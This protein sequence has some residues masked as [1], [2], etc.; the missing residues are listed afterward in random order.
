[1]NTF[2]LTLRDSDIPMG[3]PATRVY[4]SGGSITIEGEQIL[5]TVSPTNFMPPT[6]QQDAEAAA[7]STE[8]LPEKNC[9]VRR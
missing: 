1:M 2:A 3:M 6:S 5:C 7:Q 4:V 9:R 8:K